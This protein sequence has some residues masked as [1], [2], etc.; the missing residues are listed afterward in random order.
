LAIGAD[1]RSIE[2]AD[3]TRKQESKM[4][5]RTAFVSGS[6][7]AVALGGAL[8]LAQRSG[9]A[10]SQPSAAPAPL[11]PVVAGAVRSGDV[12]IYLT[13]IG[14]VQAYNTVVVRS[15]VE[16]KLTD[17]AFKEGQAV[18]RGDLLAQIDPRPYQAQLDQAVATRDRDEAQLANAKANLQR[19][20][21]LLPK[22]FATPQLVDTQKAQVA[23]LTAAVK[24]D[25]AMIEAAQVQL[26]Y[27]RLT[28]PIDGVTGIRQIDVG[29]V[30][31]PTDANGLVVVTQ[32]QPISVIF[33]LPETDLPQI[34]EQIAKGP[35]TALAY[36]EDDRQ[37]LD[38]GSL[39]LVDNEILQ[40]S[41]SVRLKANFPNAANRLWPG[42]LIDMRLLIDTRHDGLTIP[43]TAVQQ[44]PRGAYVYVIKPDQTVESHAVTTTPVSDGRVLVEKGLAAGEQVVLAGQSRLQPGSR[45]TILTGRAAQ[46]FAAANAQE[47]AP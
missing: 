32:L 30:I 6:L 46:D 11:V 33:T 28:A 43:A 8:M 4:R 31:H 39:G 40:T 16:G 1:R 21:P 15:Q 27:T 7:I 26:S 23:Q 13:G 2:I 35:L 20:L 19:Y 12:P 18:H 10:A 9:T 42:E 22:G 24:S 25:K 34:Q 47:V 41:G 29:N 5:R 36:T 44:G 17:V 14:N 3:E 37:Q 45:V 38:R